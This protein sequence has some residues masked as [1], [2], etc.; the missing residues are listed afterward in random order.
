MKRNAGQDMDL[1]KQWRPATQM[2]RGGTMRTEVTMP[3]KL[4]RASGAS[5]QA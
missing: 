3:R 1:V 5:G 4:L 2:V